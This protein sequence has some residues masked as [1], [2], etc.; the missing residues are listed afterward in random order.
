V[1]CCCAELQRI[2]CLKSTRTDSDCAKDADVKKSEKVLVLCTTRRRLGG[3]ATELC[4]RNGRE[5]N[6]L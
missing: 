2:S 1:T 4:G 6:G 3:K 5:R